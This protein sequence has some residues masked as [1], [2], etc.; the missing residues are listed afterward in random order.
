MQSEPFLPPCV[1]PSR[2]KARAGAAAT[3][4]A[5]QTP[6]VVGTPPEEETNCEVTQRAVKGMAS[7]PAGD[8]RSDQTVK[9]DSA[10]VE[11]SLELRAGC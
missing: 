3:P 11:M 7:S 8:G 10:R 5:G 9:P 4:A 6:M 2:T 1:K